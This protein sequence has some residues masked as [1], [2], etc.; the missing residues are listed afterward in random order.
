MD[1]TKITLHIENVEGVEAKV[2]SL[3]GQLNLCFS[4]E[5]RY[6]EA[7]RKCYAISPEEEYL[8]NAKGVAQW[9]TPEAL[10][11]ADQKGHVEIS[12]P[13]PPVSMGLDPNLW[14]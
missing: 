6:H 7:E 4:P 14:R 13:R 12:E 3:V 5:P 1:K 2:L 10:Y 11:D 8:V 9:E